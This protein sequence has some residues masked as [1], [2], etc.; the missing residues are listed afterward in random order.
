M[1]A[2]ETA[3]RTL[4]L[5]CLRP[6]STCWCRHLPSLE[7]KTR[8]LI[9]Q[10]P[11]E[12]YVAIGTARMAHLSLPGSMLRI[13][14]DFSNDPVVREAL[15]GPAVL[16]YPGRDARDL[17][18]VVGEGPLTLVVVDG[19][20]PNARKLLR[21]NPL[22][23]A[24][25]QVRFTPPRPGEYRIRREPAAH[26]VATIEALAH[27]LGKLEG[28]PERFESLLVPFRAMVDLQ[29]EHKAR[30]IGRPVTRPRA[31]PAGLLTL[32]AA[33]ERIVCVHG[34]ANAWPAAVKGA[35]RAEI[36][37]WLAVRIATGERF[38]AVVAPLNP[39]AA[40]TAHNLGVS[41][42]AIRAGE[43][44]EAFAARLA[45]FVQGDDLI[46]T[47]RT[48]ATHVLDQ[49]L[50]VLPPSRLD[51]RPVASQV[52]RGKTGSITDFLERMGLPAPAPSS[53]RATRRLAALETA[54]RALLE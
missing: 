43:T 23:A 8:V 11:R 34:E 50:A 46:V 7:T 30:G 6:E 36:V 15:A 38:S 22:L 27:V 41:E 44:R 4:C 52:V 32:R 35:P 10:H 39:I 19:T 20:W 17:D 51:L 25:P 54:T 18:E 13:G 40:T 2:T 26:C 12:R 53:T 3:E 9:L 33:R 1:E 16:L 42:D 49:E 31:T 45:A 28:D 37:Q 14:M 24:L 29:L 47:W 48:Y 21:R 5:R